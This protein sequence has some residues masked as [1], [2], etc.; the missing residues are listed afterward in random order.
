MMDK[1][2]LNPSL[3]YTTLDAI[4]TAGYVLSTVTSKSA[5]SCPPQRTPGKAKTPGM[6]RQQGGS[7]GQRRHHQP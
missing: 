6:Y 4:S 5:F 3:P 7:H 2:R 1:T